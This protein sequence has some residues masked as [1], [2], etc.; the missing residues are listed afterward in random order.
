MNAAA[1]LVLTAALVAP[2][3]ARTPDL[4]GLPVCED[5]AGRVV[6]LQDQGARGDWVLFWTASD[7]DAAGEMV[8]A[9]CRS[10]RALR[11][12]PGAAEGTLAGAAAIMR[13]AMWDE[14]A[15]TLGDIQAS[16]RASGY[17]ASRVR[18]PLT[19]CACDLAGQA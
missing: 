4:Q 16:L 3:G 2:A 8:L 12:N 15:Q 17:R 13:G 6:E 7:R 14:E 10:G 9:S 1:P 18:I 19:H 11:V 5:E